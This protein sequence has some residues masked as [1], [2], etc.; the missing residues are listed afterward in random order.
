MG[1]SGSGKSTCIQLLLRFY[2]PVKGK[3]DVDGVS[4]EDFK[5]EFMRSHM[6]LV[7]QEP[8]L[9]NRTIAENIAYG[10][11]SKE[12][13]MQEIISAAKEAQIHSEFISKLP[14][15]NINYSI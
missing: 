10:D 9:F 7:S 13:S 14:Q 5:L 4:S 11:N 2:D 3:V 8:I 15:V 12:V 1:P 6:G